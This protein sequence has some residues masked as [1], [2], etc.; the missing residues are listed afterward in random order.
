MSYLAF[1][2]RE[3]LF[4][5]LRIFPLFIVCAEPLNPDSDEDDENP[6]SDTF[7]LFLSFTSLYIGCIEIYIIAL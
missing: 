7:R 3:Q 2:S 6:V 1:V 5:K 4:N